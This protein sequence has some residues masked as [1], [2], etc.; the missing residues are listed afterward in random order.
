MTVPPLL[1]LVSRTSHR[2]ESEY[3]LDAGLDS[4][5]RAIELAEQPSEALAVA[6]LLLRARARAA[7]AVVE[8]VDGLRT[9]VRHL[10]ETFRFSEEG[11]PERRMQLEAALANDPVKGL[12]DWL[13][14]WFTAVSQ[15]HTAAAARL[16]HVDHMPAGAARLLE[17]CETAGCGV[18]QHDWHVANPVLGAGAA[19]VTIGDRTVPEDEGTRTRLL[20]VLARLALYRGLA[21][22]AARLL[23]KAEEGGVDIPT[24]EALR[25]WKWRLRG[26]RERAL[27]HLSRASRAGPAQLEVVVETIELAIG[28]DR[29]EIGLGAARVAVNSLL[30]LQS[31]DD[32]ATRLGREPPPEVWIAAGERALREEDFELFESAVQ[33]ASLAASYDD[34]VMQAVIAELTLTG[35][36]QRDAPLEERVEALMRAGDARLDAG[37]LDMAENH[38]ERAHRLTPDD[39]DPALK[40]AD[41]VIALHATDPLETG[42]EILE[43]SLELILVAQRRGAITSENAWTYLSESSAR[44]R[45]A[46]QAGAA[47]PDHL[48]RAFVAVC[49]ALAYAPYSAT[50]WVELSIVAGALNLPLVAVKTAAQAVK[51]DPF[52]DRSQN[53][54]ILALTNLGRVGEALDALEGHTDPWDVAVRGYLLARDGN[55]DG[56]VEVLR[57][58][59]PDLT[60][61]WAW[62]T[63]MWCLAITER[64][65]EAIAEA[66]RLVRTW[67]TRLDEEGGLQPSMWAALMLGDFSRAEQLGRQLLTDP[68][69]DDE[70]PIGLAR[71]LGGDHEGG[72]EAVCRSFDGMKTTRELAEW[73]VI[74]EPFLQVVAKRYGVTLPALDSIG[75]AV[76]RR[77]DELVSPPDALAE[78]RDAA[79]EATDSQVGETAIGFGAT[80]IRLAADDP[81]GALD[82]LESAR[83]EG[84]EVEVLADALRQQ[85]SVRAEPTGEPGVEALALEAADAARRGADE[86]ATQALKGLLDAAPAGAEALL[87]TVTDGDPGARAGLAHALQGLADSPDHDTQALALQGV[88]TGASMSQPLGVELALPLSWFE[89]YPDPVNDHPLFLRFLPEVRVRAA[90]Y[91]PSIHVYTDESLEP[92]GYRLHTDGAVVGEGTADPGYVLVDTEALPLLGAHVANAAEPSETVGMARLPVELAETG[93]GLVQ[94]LAQSALEHVARLA[95]DIAIQYADAASPSSPSNSTVVQ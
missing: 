56:A 64:E 16:L 14:E 52:G 17:R 44:Q 88:L 23:D 20:L 18:D 38:Y 85:V 73:R 51:L 94:L 76:K 11:W 43:D 39:P 86:E 82:A 1:D 90:V 77:A 26:D 87:L 70:L 61:G 65:D 67:E 83:L 28:D 72:V 6:K 30:V 93:G 32:E 45:L 46:E 95:G 24:L 48:W 40:L 78:L 62:L 15:G 7:R 74:I 42:R 55:P 58:T 63:L 35:V 79:A 91:V 47:E 84:P 57:S 9:K 71:I 2:I 29:L 27:S 22:D 49:R 33:R 68:D 54:H 53:Q 3:E 66:T 12:A 36:E 75:E 41:C 19:G 92:A 8:E 60:W 37:Q 59:S 69:K 21:D 31:L 81:E 50:R 34:P 89:D 10:A 25:A 80:F 13:D 4:V 5:L